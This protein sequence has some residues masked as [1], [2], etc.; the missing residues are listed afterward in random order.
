ML[1]QKPFT[2]IFIHEEWVHNVVGLIS[3][4]LERIERYE[5]FR[6]KSL[7]TGLAYLK[8]SAHICAMNLKLLSGNLVTCV[9]TQRNSYQRGAILSEMKLLKAKPV[10]SASR[11]AAWQQ[12]AFITKANK[13]KNYDYL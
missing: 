13:G 8:K 3:N 5:L 12:E 9:Q 4:R 11:L 2:S 7:A 1:V 10:Q 6:A